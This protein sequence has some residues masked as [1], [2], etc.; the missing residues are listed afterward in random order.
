MWY[1]P[2]KP[3][4]QTAYRHLTMKSNSTTGH[5]NTAW[6]IYKLPLQCF[7]LWWTRN[8]K[9]RMIYT[10]ETI[11]SN[12]TV[13]MFLLLFIYLMKMSIWFSYTLEAWAKKERYCNKGQGE[14]EEEEERACANSEGS[15]WSEDTVLGTVIS[16]YIHGIL[17]VVKP[18][19]LTKK[20]I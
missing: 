11:T 12:G 8:I 3:Q 13:M 5:T 16:D 9:Q 1:S 10:T 4:H 17:K 20:Q 14:E 2:P 6:K 18:L 15:G 19:P 7:S